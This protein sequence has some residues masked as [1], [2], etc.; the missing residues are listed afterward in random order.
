[1][2]KTSA[3]LDRQAVEVLLSALEAP[4]SALSAAALQSFPAQVGAQLI[5]AALIKPDGH[6]AVATSLADHDDIPVTL[7]WSAE[8]RGFG[9]FSPSRGWVTVPNASIARYRV[10]V[11][12]VLSAM[13]SNVAVSS[14]GA[15][16]AI[17]PDLIW[18]LGDARLAH[19]THRVPIWFARRLFEPDVWR[20]LEDAAKARPA[21]RLRIILTSTSSRRLP[22][23]VL[24]RHLIV[25]VQDVI[26]ND[27]SLALDPEILSAR[28]DGAPAAAP[29]APIVII[30]EGREV[31]LFG[32]VFRFPKAVHQRRIIRFLYERY[33][34]G[35]L[36]V[37]SDEIV[38]ELDLRD[39]ARIRD[40]FKKS[41]AW[42]S[43]LT[44]R[45]GMCGF[46]LENVSR[47][48]L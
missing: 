7:T 33:L 35:E 3:P 30:G 21:P 38:T 20:Q 45:G 12:D 39:G 47:D 32:R 16:H 17:V 22:K 19:R 9:Y 44:E 37:S 24:S 42:N 34:Q 15:L 28:L 23:V 36:M 5:A 11:P 10:N 29:E 26:K 41:T 46:C 4:R 27:S 8:H 43:L 48:N 31:R 2:S 1:M 25:P 6:E 13:T 40:F 14:S 18:D